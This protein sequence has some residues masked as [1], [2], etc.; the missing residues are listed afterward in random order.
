MHYQWKQK[1]DQSVD[2]SAQNIYPDNCKRNK[3]IGK[4]YWYE[5]KNIQFNKANHTHSLL[6]KFDPHH[7]GGGEPENLPM[8]TAWPITRLYHPLVDTWFVHWSHLE[9]VLQSLK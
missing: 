7:V 9:G 2:S 1:T 8:A 3:I 5:I 6:N 4:K